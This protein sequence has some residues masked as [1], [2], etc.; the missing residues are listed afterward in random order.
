MDPASWIETTD[1]KVNGGEFDEKLGK[2]KADTK[3][4]Q[5]T[6]YISRLTQITRFDWGAPGLSFGIASDMQILNRTMHCVRRTN[7]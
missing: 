7:Q 2:G 5:N 6:Q 4:V 3:F 1:F